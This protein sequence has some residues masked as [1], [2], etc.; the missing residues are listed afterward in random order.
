MVYGLADAIHLFIKAVM[1]SKE[2][3][4]ERNEEFL[5]EEMVMPKEEIEE[6]FA[7]EMMEMVAPKEEVTIY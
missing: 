3:N 6:P 4:E 7:E 1:L 2:V 5:A